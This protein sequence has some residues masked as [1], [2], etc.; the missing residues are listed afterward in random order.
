MRGIAEMVFSVYERMLEAHGPH[1]RI[2]VMGDSAGAA[3]AL[4]LLHHI[5]R[6]GSS[7][8]M[9][10]HAT[11]ISPAQPVEKNPET[12]RA[13]RE[14]DKSNADIMLSLSYMKT[15]AELCGMDENADNY[16]DSPLY[17]SFSGFPPV[18]LWAGTADIVFPQAEALAERARQDGADIVFHR[19][20]NMMHVWPLLPFAP[21]CV[22]AL[23]EIIGTIGRALFPGDGEKKP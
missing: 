14:I 7:L 19:G 6:P 21:E 1:A 4:A 3:L 13:M 20:K 11:L 8:P 18:D 2:A 5:N 9:P 15:L 23:N 17:G 10:C 12:L 16:I 22:S